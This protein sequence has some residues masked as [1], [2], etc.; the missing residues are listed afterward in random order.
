MGGPQSDR[1]VGKVKNWL[2]KNN[3]SHLREALDNLTVKRKP[4]VFLSAVT[5]PQ[6]GTISVQVAVPVARTPVGVLHNFIREKVHGDLVRV[7]YN[8]K[9]V[10]TNLKGR[11][12]RNRVYRAFIPTT[13]LDEPGIYPLEVHL[14]DGRHEKLDVDI[15]VLERKF[16]V[17][18][19]WLEAEQ[20]DLN[21]GEFEFQQVNNATHTKGQA[22]QQWGGAFLRPCRGRI[23][24]EYGQRRFYNGTWAEQ[25]FHRGVDYAAAMGTP[26][27]AP[28][29]GVVNL[30]G[31]ERDGFNVH[32]N[33]VGIDHGH[34]VVS[35]LMHLNSIDVKRGEYI[36]AGKVVGKVG[37]TGRSTGPHLH[38]GLFV[39]GEAVDPDPW[40]ENA[41]PAADDDRPIWDL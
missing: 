33:V 16:G 34:G 15:G 37:T 2:D 6:G 30:I 10:N 8:D 12:Q 39:G 35:L 40:M 20:N 41:S 29:G 1:V 4:R 19:L 25:Y 5:I 17:Q 14:N 21:L 28:C 38:W 18:H 24:T 11:L 23:S 26:V 22:K 27:K 13:P 3:L 32:G 36:Q 9:P 7:V 31:Y